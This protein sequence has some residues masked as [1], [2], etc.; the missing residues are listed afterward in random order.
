M[1]RSGSP[2]WANGL[3]MAE[4]LGIPDQNGCLDEIIYKRG[5][6]HSTKSCKADGS[7]HS[8][9]SVVFL[10]FDHLMKPAVSL[11]EQDG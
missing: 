8:I 5:L 2:S 3:E 9:K 7:F 6:T 11:N 10:H 1:W 4:T